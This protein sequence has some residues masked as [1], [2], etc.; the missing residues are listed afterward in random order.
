MGA[1]DRRKQDV[2]VIVALVLL[3]TLCSTVGLLGSFGVW[4]L[5]MTRIGVLI[6]KVAVRGLALMVVV[7]AFSW[8]FGGG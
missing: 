6:A 2:L 4:L 1:R 3:V 5:L 7:A 8:L